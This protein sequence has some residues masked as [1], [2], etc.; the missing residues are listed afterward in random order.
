M[1]LKQNSLLPDIKT[2][3]QACDKLL[4]T[5]VEENHIDFLA[6]SGIELG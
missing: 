1:K 5:R 3:N 2:A 6:R 4:L